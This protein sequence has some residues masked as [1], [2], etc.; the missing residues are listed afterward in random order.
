MTDKHSY[1]VQF[2]VKILCILWVALFLT[3]RAFLFREGLDMADDA[4]AAHRAMQKTCETHQKVMEIEREMC[5]RH[6]TGAKR[7]RERWAVEHVIENTYL[8]GYDSC[9]A[10]ADALFTRLGF[11]AVAALGGIVAVY[12]VATKLLGF[13]LS[14][15]R[16]IQYREE[17]YFD[18]RE[19]RQIGYTP[20]TVDGQTARQRRLPVINEVV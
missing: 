4:I 3:S 6:I 1:D 2:V 13:S 15:H 20:S 10:L 7:G 14:G 16:R 11:Y 17:P 18:E 8:C 12:L 5:I 19:K 9:T